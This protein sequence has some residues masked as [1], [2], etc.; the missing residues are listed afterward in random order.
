MEIKK[1]D[2]CYN[3]KHYNSDNDFCDK[4]KEDCEAWRMWE[5]KCCEQKDKPKEERNFK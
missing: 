4:H 2:T 5:Y 1:K 3:C